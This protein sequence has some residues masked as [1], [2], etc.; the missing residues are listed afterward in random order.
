MLAK[1]YPIS[2]ALWKIPIRMALDS[3]AALKALLAGDVLFFK[4]VIKAKLAFIRWLFTSKKNN[5]F[6]KVKKGKVNGYFNGSIV[7]KYFIQ[8]KKTF[9]EIIG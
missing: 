7:W 3:I 1:N 2:V 8:K 5:T 6:S 4:A 9:K